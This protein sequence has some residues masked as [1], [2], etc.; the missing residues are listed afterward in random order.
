V[1]LIWSADVCSGVFNH[2]HCLI[3]ETIGVALLA[4]SVC[5]QVGNRN[6]PDSVPRSEPLQVGSPCHC[7]VIP[8]DFTDDRRRIQTRHPRQIN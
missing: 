7:T 4:S 3:P 2:L 1:L 5:D 6:D 8:H